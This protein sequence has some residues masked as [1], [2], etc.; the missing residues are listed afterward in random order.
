M[1]EPA[2]ILLNVVEMELAA[3]PRSAEGASSGISSRGRDR[4]PLGWRGDAPVD[5]LSG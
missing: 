3:R 4:Q 5:T 2:W 1:A